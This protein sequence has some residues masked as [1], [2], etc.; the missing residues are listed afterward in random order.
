[1]KAVLNSNGINTTEKTSFIIK[2]DY[3]IADV[4]DAD[5]S[6]FQIFDAASDMYKTVP[7]SKLK[8]DGIALSEQTRANAITVTFTP[9]SELASDEY[10]AMNFAVE[11]G[12]IQT[13]N[14]TLHSCAEII[15]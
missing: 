12:Y 14:I 13:A 15:K 11:K 9:T 1:M 6:Y 8:I 4:P 3:S 10:D 2:D 7:I 5:K